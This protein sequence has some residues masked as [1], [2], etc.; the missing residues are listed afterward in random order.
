MKYQQKHL[1]ED[2]L[3]K[4]CYAWSYCYAFVIHF[5]GTFRPETLLNGCFCF[6]LLRVKASDQTT[7]PIIGTLTP[8][9]AGKHMFKVN[10]SDTKT[11]CRIYS[12]LSVKTEN[13]AI[14]V[15]FTV[16]FEE[17]SKINVVS[18]LLILNI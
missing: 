12:K 6:V 2:D 14:L 7:K 13:N 18:Q 17:R 16:N 3:Q 11:G 8:Y 9:P 5:L 4:R 10:N 15:T 1:L